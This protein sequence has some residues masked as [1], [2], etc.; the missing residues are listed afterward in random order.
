MCSPQ[1]RQKWTIQRSISCRPVWT[2]FVV[3]T[4]PTCLLSPQG[5]TCRPFRLYVDH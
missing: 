3:D 4:L 5:Y 1:R 2:L